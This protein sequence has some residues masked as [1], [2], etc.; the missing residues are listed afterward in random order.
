MY[1]PTPTKDTN[2]KAPK[3]NRHHSTISSVYPQKP[4]PSALPEAEKHGKGMKV[5]TKHG[6]IYVKERHA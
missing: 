6:S 4:H 3:T 5:W 2:Q 1:L